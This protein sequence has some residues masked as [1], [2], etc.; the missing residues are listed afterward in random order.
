MIIFLLVLQMNRNRRRANKV[1]EI[2]NTLDMIFIKGWH[3]NAGCHNKNYA[4]QI[5]SKQ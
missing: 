5:K 4:Y 3:V 1:R 2:Q